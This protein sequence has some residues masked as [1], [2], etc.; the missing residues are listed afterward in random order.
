[1]QVTGHISTCIK[2]KFCDRPSAYASDQVKMQVMQV[3]Y[4]H[5]KGEYPMI[6][7][8]LLLALRSYHSKTK[9]HQRDLLERLQE[10]MEHELCTTTSAQQMVSR[11]PLSILQ[12]QER[13]MLPNKLRRYSRSRT[14]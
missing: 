1:M 13:R 9:A 10:D 3:G 14:H 11:C 6:L 5:L 2:F 4:I 7:A 12:S 8:C